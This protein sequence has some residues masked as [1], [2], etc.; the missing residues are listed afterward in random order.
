M[1]Q[2]LIPLPSTNRMTRSPAL[3][4]GT[5]ATAMVTSP[6]VPPRNC[7]TIG[8]CALPLRRSTASK[9]TWV[10]ITRLPSVTRHSDRVLRTRPSNTRSA[11]LTICSKVGGM[12]VVPTV[13]RADARLRPR[14][15]IAWKFFKNC[16][17]PRLAIERD[18]WQG[19][20]S[21]KSFCDQV[22]D[23]KHHQVD[24]AS[25]AR[26]RVNDNGRLIGRI[27]S[28][29]GMVLDAI[30]VQPGFGSRAQLEGMHKRPPVQPAMLRVV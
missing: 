19:G 27:G 11:L 22:A 15:M 30:Q 12:T 5:S 9:S 4:F 10:K 24:P 8:P 20:S 1:G 18:Y 17:C 3:N 21:S 28:G 14:R 29:E 7:K 16:H 26:R 6:T 2:K 25:A 23:C 13:K